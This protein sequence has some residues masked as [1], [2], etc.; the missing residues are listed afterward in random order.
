MTVLLNELAAIGARCIEMLSTFWVYFLIGIA[1]GALIRTYRWHIKI[2][3]VLGRMGHWAI[4]VAAVTAVASPLCSCGFIPIFITMVCSG[5][6]LSVSI[7]LL[8]AAPIMSPSGFAVTQWQLGLDWAI[9]ETL[10]G[11]LMG[12]FGGYVVLALEKRW[13]PI[14]WIIT[15]PMVTDI[16][17]PDCPGDLKC[18]CPDKFSN[19]LAAKHLPTWQVFLAKFWELALVT[20]KFTLM[21]LIIQ[22]VAERYIPRDWIQAFFG[23][24]D[25]LSIALVTLL[26]V[27][28]PV[29]QITAAATVFTFVDKLG[30]ANGTAF[31]FLIGGPVASLP[32]MAMLWGMFRKRVVAIYMAIALVGTVVMAMV[33]QAV[34]P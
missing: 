32:A 10:A 15:G 30:A 11:I 31:A 22:A 2:R 25:L 17:A 4:P 24:G 6:P 20:A 27:P 33:F 1:V 23:G 19:R 13:F 28:I 5:V 3:K 12:M 29:N 9:A 34:M 18:N 16:H 8:L 7:A 14:P 26:A 21:G